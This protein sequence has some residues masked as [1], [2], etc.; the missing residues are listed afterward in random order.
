M[1]DFPDETPPSAAAADWISRILAAA[2]T[3]LL[4]G[5]AGG[6]LA[7]RWGTN[8]LGLVG[9]LLGVSL[10]TWY[11]IVVTQDDT[12]RGQSGSERKRDSEDE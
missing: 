8:C 1:T 3:M 7:K 4:P 11:L 5:L 10:G 6:W 12:K 2:A 9:L